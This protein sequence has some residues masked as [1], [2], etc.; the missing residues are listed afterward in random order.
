MDDSRKSLAKAETREK[1]LQKKLEAMETEKNK[2]SS[3]SME[4]LNEDD[5][6]IVSQTTKKMTYSMNKDKNKENKPG[7]SDE[8]DEQRCMTTKFQKSDVER[9]NDVERSYGGH[10][11]H[12]SLTLSELLQYEER[13]ARCSALKA[14]VEYQRMYDANQML[15]RELLQEQTEQL[16]ALRGQFFRK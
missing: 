15:T 4:S 10:S 7:N 5:Y 3:C 14:K 2:D 13:I 9:S 16:N 8:N 6:N 1:Q 12:A 11:H